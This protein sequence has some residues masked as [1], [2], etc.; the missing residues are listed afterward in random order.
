[1][2]RTRRVELATRG[3][4]KLPAAPCGIVDGVASSDSPVIG[5]TSPLAAAGAAVGGSFDDPELEDSVRVVL[6]SVEAEL[7][8][9]VMSAD[10]GRAEGAR[11]LVDAGGKRFRPLLVAL[12]AQSAEPTAPA[13]AQAAVV[14]ELTHL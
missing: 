10:P 6:E 7:Y 2:A 14:I 5:G 3:A 8:R 13:V 11:H 9:A 1:M 4:S 12:A